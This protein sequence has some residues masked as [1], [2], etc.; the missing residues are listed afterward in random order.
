ML[1]KMTL[2]E[3]LDRMFTCATAERCVREEACFRI[4][5][6]MKR[7]LDKERL[8]QALS[9]PQPETQGADDEDVMGY[10]PEWKVTPHWESGRMELLDWSAA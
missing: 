4:V 10:A 2:E 6:E 3:A 9:Q 7:R 8:H 1:T 5:M